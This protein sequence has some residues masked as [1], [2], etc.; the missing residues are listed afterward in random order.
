[1]LRMRRSSCLLVSAFCLLLLAGCGGGKK[2][3]EVKG[4]LVL[5]PTLKLADTDLVKIALV[6]E[7]LSSM[8]SGAQVSNSDLTFSTR[9]GK[10][11]GGTAPGKYKVTIQMGAYR[12][13]AGSQE[14]DV[15]FTK[16]NK[17][18][19]ATKTPLK[20]EIGEEL[21]QSITIDLVKNTVTKN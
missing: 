12:G 4:K 13:S 3:V 8:A 9:E 11:Q 15:V 20:V 10:K 19:D 1:M 5:P 6:P 7:E 16:F 21:E 18:Y 14:R 17:F 2:S